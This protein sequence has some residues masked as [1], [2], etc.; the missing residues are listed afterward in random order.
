MDSYFGKTTLKEI[1]LNSHS[2][3]NNGDDNANE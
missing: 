2:Y 3:T 1:I